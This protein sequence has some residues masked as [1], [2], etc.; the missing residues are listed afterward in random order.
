LIP[1]IVNMHGENT[2]KGNVIYGVLLSLLYTFVK[3]S[4][5]NAN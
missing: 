2:M 3:Y 4:I 5:N 1:G